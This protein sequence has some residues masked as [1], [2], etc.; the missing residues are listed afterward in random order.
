[1][2]L[3][4][5]ED[6]VKN[7]RNIICALYNNKKIY[8]FISSE[9]RRNQNSTSIPLHRMAMPH[10]SVLKRDI[11]VQAKNESRRWFSAATRQSHRSPLQVSIIIYNMNLAMPSYD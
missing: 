7:K 1:M 8:Y 9:R 3:I 11:G 5:T 2:I 6:L 10:L 4:T